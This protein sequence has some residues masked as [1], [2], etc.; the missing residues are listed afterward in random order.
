MPADKFIYKDQDD[1]ELLSYVSSLDE[2][3]CCL[4][5][6]SRIAKGDMMWR[7]ILSVIANSDGPQEE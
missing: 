4:W 6:A 2:Q 1:A 7:D 3:T 5:H